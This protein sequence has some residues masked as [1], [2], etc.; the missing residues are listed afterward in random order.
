[1]KDFTNFYGVLY[2]CPVGDRCKDCPIEK[3]ENISFMDK[4]KWFDNLCD[5]EKF[6]IE[7]QHIECS[8]K[9]NKRL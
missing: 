7:N 1:M 9:R 3:T 4:L 5:G 8:N 6:N 2:N